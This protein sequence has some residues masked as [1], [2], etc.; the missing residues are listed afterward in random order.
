M[1]GRAQLADRLPL[2]RLGNRALFQICRGA[3]RAGAG[4]DP[5][6]GRVGRLAVAQCHPRNSNRV[7]AGDRP[8]RRRLR[9]ELGATGRQRYR[10]HA[11][12]VRAQ[13]EM[14]RAAQA[15]RTKRDAS[16]GPARS[17]GAGGPRHV[18]RHPAFGVV[19]AGRANPDRR[20][21]R[22]R[23]GAYAGRIFARS[24]TMDSLCFPV[25]QPTTIASKSSRRP[26]NTDCPL[27]T[28]TG[29]TSPPAG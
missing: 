21:R 10:F 6:R 8:G 2:G 4:C 13:L 15:D 7:R 28:P 23:V 19:I 17:D 5:C 29:T 20:E 27:L 16:G 24:R 1:A 22:G 18:R 3:G 25:R 9:R 26:R 12:R 14:D 11:V